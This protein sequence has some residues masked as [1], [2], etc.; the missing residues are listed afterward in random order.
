MTTIVELIS[1]GD[2]VLTGH[3]IDSN[4]AYI[5]RAVLDIGCELKWRVT[6]GDDVA[7]IVQ[8]IR[9]ALS[10][11]DVVIT[12]GGLGPTHDDRTKEALCEVFRIP[13]VH[14]QEILDE[15]LRRYALRNMLMPK[16][17]EN[18]AMLPRGA[19]LFPDTRPRPAPH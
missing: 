10:R 3:T 1:I 12:T 14:H 2:E 6:V 16:S 15:I 11:A 4:A 9:T 13:L 7:D 5:A 17:N 8:A 18:Q 19:R